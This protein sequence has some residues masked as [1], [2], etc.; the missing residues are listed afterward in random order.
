MIKEK[1]FWWLFLIL[2][3]AAC[4]TLEPVGASQLRLTPSVTAAASQTPSRTAATITPDASPFPNALPSSTPTVS[5]SPQ[6][7]EPE[8]CSPLQGIPFAELSQILTNPY[9]QPR[10]GFDEGHPGID[11]S[12]WSRGERKAMKGHPVQSVLEGIVATIIH[13]RMPYGNAIIIE[14]S[15]SRWSN[16]NKLKNFIPAPIATVVPDARLNCPKGQGVNAPQ[17]SNL[18]LYLLYAHLDQLPSFRPGDSITC[19]QI[20]GL[21]GTTGA[22]KNDHLHFETRVGPAGI[23]YNSIAHY[24]NDATNEEMANYCSWR[25]SGLFQSIDPNK[26]LNISSGR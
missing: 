10:L 5:P 13:N 7:A 4:S 16:S 22:S 11:F 18:S 26:L 2:L 12:Y 6:P 15:L 21:V 8:L 14:S 23:R 20:I 24:T 1:S 3:L 17:T 19:G 9:S 25:V